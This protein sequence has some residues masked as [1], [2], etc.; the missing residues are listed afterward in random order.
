MEKIIFYAKEVTDKVLKYLNITNGYF[1]EFSRES[2][3]SKF[4]KIISKIFMKYI[5]ETKISMEYFYSYTCID[6]YTFLIF[7][8]LDQICQFSSVLSIK[9]I[10]FRD[11]RTETGQSMSLFESTSSWGGIETTLLV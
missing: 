5:I 7:S 11:S 10:K 4:R 3:L 2:R 6:W 8:I 1:R 9:N